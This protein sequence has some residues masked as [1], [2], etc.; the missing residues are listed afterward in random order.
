M[1]FIWNV[2]A[3]EQVRASSER[4]MEA[5][6]GNM[7]RAAGELLMQA[8][9]VEVEAVRLQATL[10]I[11]KTTTGTTTEEREGTR[12][13]SKGE[14]ES[15]TYTAY[16]EYTREVEDAVAIARV[17]AEI[18]QRRRLV[19]ALRREAKELSDEARLLLQKKAS[20][21]AMFDELFRMA[22]ET[23]HRYAARIAAFKGDI[24]RYMA[25]IQEL[26]DSIGK[27]TICGSTSIGAIFA[28]QVHYPIP[29]SNIRAILNKDADD[30]MPAQFAVLAEIFVTIGDDVGATE[31]F[32]NYIAD[33]VVIPPGVQDHMMRGNT[34]YTICPRKVAGI[35]LPLE[36][37]IAL[38][39]EAQFQLLN[40]GARA[41]DPAVENLTNIRLQLMERSA[42]LSV[43]GE[44]ATVTTQQIGQIQNP[45][46][47]VLVD[48]NS[49]REFPG[50]FSLRQHN[51]VVSGASEQ[52]GI[53]LAVTH[54]VLST[55]TDGSNTQAILSTL[56]E[57]ADHRANVGF[58]G[59]NE[60]RISRAT[61]GFGA[62]M[63]FLYRSG[64]Y[65]QQRHQF[66]LSS[67]LLSQ[68]VS[69]G[70]SSL[71]G[72][73]AG[74]VGEG[75]AMAASF[76]KN[77]DSGQKIF[78]QFQSQRARAESVQ[79]DI[80]NVVDSAV[81]GAFY[82]LFALDAVVISER[83]APP[84]SIIWP[85]LHT[86]ASVHGLNSILGEE[87]RYGNSLAHYQVT[88]EQFLQDPYVVLDLISRSL[89]EQ[90]RRPFFSLG[91]PEDP[92]R[93]FDINALS[94]RISGTISAQVFPEPQASSPQPA[95][96]Q[97]IPPVIPSNTPTEHIPGNPLLN[98]MI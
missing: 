26:Y 5:Q 41:L 30:I 67:F 55:R 75:A 12:T 97:S 50:P 62:N 20:T 84:Q 93:L 8:T 80:A 89:P 32:L 69:A 57:P 18:A 71:I 11:M 87:N 17:E 14:E 10:P 98:E 39:L 61:T 56:N 74:V 92:E 63:E 48:V 31:R 54:G 15:Y 46:Q 86:Y 70:R 95:P 6:A 22:Q 4:A 64:D 90:P 42:L 73:V 72:G 13:N 52:D 35:Q 3:A 27:T 94:R 9:R 28:N 40:D 81:Q 77:A 88:W 60:I 96:S 34:A 2:P 45:G 65:V 37:G 19:E 33:R 59:S 16:V 76:I 24:Q 44:L 47:R 36:I 25:R 85:T 43:V 51:A 79:R 49:V 83:G 68:A 66:D 91:P 53:S 7:D 21:N 78:S 58:R 23:D 38:A 29:W 1:D 82:Q